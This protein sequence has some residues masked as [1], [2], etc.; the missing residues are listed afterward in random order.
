MR[1]FSWCVVCIA[2][3]VFYNRLWGIL[4]RPVQKKAPASLG[5]Q[6]GRVVVGLFWFRLALQGG[7]LFTNPARHR[8]RRRGRGGE[9]PHRFTISGA[10]GLAGCQWFVSLHYR[11]GPRFRRTT[12]GLLYHPKSLAPIGQHGASVR[13]RQARRS[14]HKRPGIPCQ[15]RVYR[16]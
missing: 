8:G 15:R 10:E 3:I 12:G 11:R 5:N 2:C 6:P 16:G 4:A 7:Y 9:R 13:F 1:R 14:G